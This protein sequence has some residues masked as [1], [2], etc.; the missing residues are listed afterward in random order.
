MVKIYFLTIFKK[1]EHMFDFLILRCYTI[2]TNNERRQSMLDE[3]RL[4]IL[5]ESAKYDVSCSSSGS[6]RKNAAGGLGNANYAGICHS[7]TEDGRCISLLKILLT[8]VCAYDCLYC[9]N[10]RSN[11]VPRASATPDEICELV[12]NFYKRNYIEGLFLSSAVDKNPDHTMELLLDTV[13]KLRKKYFF[14]GYIHLK[15]IPGADYSL[16]QRAAL[17]ADRMSFNLELPSEKSLKL[18]APQKNK[19]AIML[20]MQ[21]VAREKSDYAAN[22]ISKFLPAGQTTQM[23]VGASPETDG[24]IIRLSQALYKKFSLKRVYYSSYLPANFKTSLLPSS[25]VGLLRE[26]RLYQADW[27]LRFYGFSAEELLDENG[28]FSKEYDPK[29]F[30][31]LNNMDKFPV[32]IN[33]AP[34]EVLVRVPGIGFRGANK[35]VRARRYGKLSFEDLARMRIVLKRAANFI[36]VNGKFFGTESV[37]LIKNSLAAVCEQERIEQ[38][39]LFSSPEIASAAVVGEL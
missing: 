32:E 3:K 33:T 19:N 17:Y 28:N 5:T 10:R 36:T 27:L 38:L 13:I 31:A 8:N 9:V 4:K 30:W 18:L 20:P 12:I 29:C 21:A 34:P 26:H 15:G 11:D 37:R 39:T 23:I 25:P 6:S 35:I 14:N 16:I 24:K 2:L 1:C 7:F 22:K